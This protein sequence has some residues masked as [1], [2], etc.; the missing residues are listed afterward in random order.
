LE[1]PSDVQ[2]EETDIMIPLCDAVDGLTTIAR[3]INVLVGVGG[4]TLSQWTVLIE[5]LGGIFGEL[6]QRNNL[7]AGASQFVGDD[8]ILSLPSKC[9]LITFQTNQPAQIYGRRFGSNGVPDK[10]DLGGISFRI[11][12]SFDNERVIES[13][14]NVYFV[15][16][17][18]TD[19]KVYLYP[20]ITGTCTFYTEEQET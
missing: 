4:S 5:I 10:F 16:P 3:T 11:A 6:C 20:L 18:A 12:G 2:V 9:K 8:A 1:I 15:P 17:N 13:T 14:S 7:T 19:V